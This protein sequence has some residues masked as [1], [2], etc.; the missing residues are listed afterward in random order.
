LAFK[1]EG[2]GPG[3]VL[4]HG[5]G[6][7]RD[8]WSEISKRLKKDHTV[9]LV[10]LPGHGDSAPPPLK[11]G[12]ADLDAIS[13]EIAKL[14]RKQK[15]EPA[16]LVG[17]SIGGAIAVRVALSDP[18]IARGIIL[19]DSTL[20]P[21]SKAFTDKLEKDLDANAGAALGDFFGG[22]CKGEVQKAKLVKDALKL[23]VPVLK[24]YVRALGSASLGTRASAIQAPVTLF[25]STALSP[26]P[27]KEKESLRQLG[28]DGFPK[29]TVSYFVDAWH[30]IMW[31]DPDT[32]EIL[33]N[34]FDNNISAGGGGGGT[35]RI[36]QAF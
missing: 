28:M 25:A 3:V 16:L 36:V 23:P 22:L 9:L 1:K 21:I 29:F 11:E 12:A 6:G 5:F 7:S 20:S 33:F 32:F 10:D 30:W 19:V 8:A 26:D 15:L 35:A 14:I 34:D 24:A 27:A 4:I 2:K 13:V 17:H 31:D 18:K